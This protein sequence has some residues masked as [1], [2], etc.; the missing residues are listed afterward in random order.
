M[1]WMLYEIPCRDQ[2]A[3]F[4]KDISGDPYYQFLQKNFFGIQVALGI[5]L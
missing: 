5:V 1:G 4:T 3:R 2:I